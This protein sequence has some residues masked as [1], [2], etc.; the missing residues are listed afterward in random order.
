MHTNDP[1]E[2]PRCCLRATPILVGCDVPRFASRVYGTSR[3]IIAAMSPLSPVMNVCLFLQQD[4]TLYDGMV[5]VME[6]E[7]GEP[8]AC[9]TLF[10]P[11]IFHVQ[12]YP[13]WVPSSFKLITRRTCGAGEQINTAPIILKLAKWDFKSYKD[14]AAELQTRVEHWL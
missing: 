6:D 13:E 5:I 1:I 11:S 4:R 9:N 14:R 8:I 3:G 10:S 12:N 7:D 2:A